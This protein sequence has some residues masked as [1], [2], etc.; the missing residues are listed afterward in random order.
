M[1]F[2]IASR[3]KKKLGKGVVSEKQRDGDE[4]F[5]IQFPFPP[6][7]VGTGSVA[8]PPVFSVGFIPPCCASSYL[9]LGRKHHYSAWEKLADGRGS[10]RG[11][12]RDRWTC[13]NDS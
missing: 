4:F 10:E 2:L 8:V 7:F 6:L 3:V 9:P 12:E 11:S 13:C 1:I 5:R